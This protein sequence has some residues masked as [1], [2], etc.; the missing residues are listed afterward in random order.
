MTADPLRYF[1]VEARELLEKLSRGVMELEKGP[2]AGDLVPRLLRHAHTLKGAA[3]VVKQLQI[4][5][6]A[7][8]VEEVLGPYR[9]DPAAVPRPL[10]DS[11]LQRI[12][13]I[14]SLVGGLQEPVPPSES[15]PSPA[16]TL[17]PEASPPPAVPGASPKRS[18]EPVEPFDPIE[19]EPR[20]IRAE[21]ADVDALADSISQAGTEATGLRQA[22]VSAE[23]IPHLAELLSENVSRPGFSNSGPMR[24]LQ[25]RLLPIA[26]ELRDLAS[27]L[28]RSF[29]SSLDRLE[30][31]LDLAH[32]G[33][34][35]LRLVPAGAVF[36]SLERAARDT[37]RAMDRR[38]SLETRGGDVRLEG[39][40]LGLVRDA[41]I[42]LVRNCV[43]HGI[44]KPKEREKAGKLPEG[45]I[46]IEVKRRG[47]LVCVRCSDD[48]KGLD[49]SAVR[50]AA[51]GKGLIA[52]DAPASTAD[53][54]VRLLLRGGLTTA[55][56]AT[57][58]S[59]HGIGLDV[60]RDAMKRLA[61]EVRVETSPGRGTTV[62]MIVPVSRSALRVLEAEAGGMIINIP[63]DS[64]RKTLRVTP[65]DV[66]RASGGERVVHNGETF[67][68]V[69]LAALLGAPSKSREGAVSAVIVG[70]G[71]RAAIATVDRLL[72]TG[73]AVLRPLP[74][75]ASNPLVAGATLDREGNPR[76][77]IDPDG[78]VRAAS[79]ALGVAAIPPQRT[80]RPKL[81]VI[82][83][84]L[85]TRILEQ[86]ILETA[87]YEVDLAVSAEEGLA[88]ARQHPY[89]LFL[90]DVEMP[91][92]DGFTF[93]E[94]VKKDPA[95]REI[96]AIL[97]TSRDS[98]EDRKR[99]RDAGAAAYT[100]KGEFDQT[101]FLEDVKRL[102]G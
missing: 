64:V 88:M 68:L 37:A 13:Q 81:L 79:G 87:G 92:M 8:A 35:R 58:A 9:N 10:I 18:P 67:P 82:D 84:S 98:P 45:L 78:L 39:F 21:A 43:A 80:G 54:L 93:V 47:S 12:D 56:T 51:E 52:P 16:A 72:G 75:L 26:E 89:G 55:G 1:R 65:N 6:E 29:S 32:E 69:S 101:V 100:A 30:R 44:E 40:T 2:P 5:E 28:S 73:G 50:K 102:A 57:Q 49:L 96:P 15:P 20:V 99:G 14:S 11:L 63:L 76:L 31:E 41:L 3:R 66:T 83:D 25:E 46:R 17:A 61:G 4:A 22:L 33:T 85:T 77:V 59:G 91:G 42:Q 24:R 53:E 27:S 19:E 86:S 62:E 38:A 97:V 36:A 74:A 95:L 23:R 70:S 94:T 90:V 71:E 60:V 48:G 7:H 34:E